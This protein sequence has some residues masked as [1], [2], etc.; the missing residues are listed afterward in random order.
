MK[1]SIL[2]KPYFYF[3]A[4]LTIQVILHFSV[5]QKDLVGFHVWRQA[6]TQNTVNSFVDEDFN[7]LNPRKNDRGSG[8]GIFRMEFPLSQWLTA[9]PVKL[10]GHAVFVS[11]IMNFLFAFLTAI[12]L[13]K[14]ISLFFKKRWIPIVGVVLLSFSPVFYYYMVNPLPDNLALCFGVWGLYGFSSWRK[15]N[16]SKY[17]IFGLVFIS[18]ASL[19]KLPFVLYYVLFAW[20]VIQPMKTSTGLNRFHVMLYGLISVIPVLA[21]YVWVI[22]DWEGNG[23]VQGIFQMTPEQKSLYWYYVWFHVRSTLP[24]LLLGWPVVPLFCL[25]IIRL[26]GN[27]KKYFRSQSHFAIL[28]SVLVA[29]LLF[30]MNM[31]EKVHDYYFM[32]L[33]P[34]LVLLMSLG[35]SSLM[36]YRLNIYFKK[37][38]LIVLILS[39]PVYTFFRIQ[40]RWDR[41]GFNSDLL[42]FREELREV[43]PTNA[44]VCA[45][46]DNSHHVFLYYVQKMGWAFENNWI[47]VQEIRGMI[48]QGCRYLYCDSRLIDQKPEIRALFGMKVAEFGSIQ[49]FEL[50]Q[51]E[52][53]MN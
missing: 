53:P 9:I 25:G 22:P 34:L 21:W 19:V 36:N 6:Q 27:A 15:T 18:L 8:D 14:W 31:I 26:A 23:I 49:V 42:K 41:L 32:P 39:L 44:L 37:A 20:S 35:V 16:K 45:G 40:S 51:P 29:Y 28:G 10:L 17:L 2:T 7:I 33:L 3:A 50:I 43:V 5:F 30:E 46:N 47:N 48:D 24:E 11:R 38:V 52:T 4:I 1:S 12:G 13:F